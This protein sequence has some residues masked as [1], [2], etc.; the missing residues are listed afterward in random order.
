MI[1][2]VNTSIEDA[3]DEEEFE[4]R[5]S[6]DTSLE[7]TSDATLKDYKRRSA[8]D[9]INRQN[10]ANRTGKADPKIAKRNAGQETAEK[11]LQGVKEGSKTIPFAGK[12]VGHKE[13]PAGQLKGTD[14]KGYPKGKLVGGG[15]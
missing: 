10:I 3:R 15:M 6:G 5:F 14:P 12:K 11:K 13:G 4:S 9:V 8:G 7:E 2:D 1:R